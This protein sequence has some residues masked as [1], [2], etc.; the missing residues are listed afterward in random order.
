MNKIE[1]ILNSIESL[2]YGSTQGQIL[3]VDDIWPQ[4]LH[5]KEN[6]KTKEMVNFFIDHY[7]KRTEIELDN[8]YLTCAYKSWMI[9]EDEHLEA[10][11]TEI[12][13]INPRIIVS[14]GRRASKY[15]LKIKDNMRSI[16]WFESIYSYHYVKRFF[17]ED[18]FYIESLNS[19]NR[20]LTTH[21]KKAL[22]R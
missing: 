12:E 11:K 13:N 10:L 2:G 21:E 19:I 7:L 9:T 6:Q 15:L 18:Q 17:D 14:L 3:L 4:Y 20:K 5:S 16:G 22:Y 8:F 1:V